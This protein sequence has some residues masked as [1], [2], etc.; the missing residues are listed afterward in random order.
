SRALVSL[1][2]WDRSHFIGAPFI[3]AST[4]VHELG[5][6]FELYHGGAV[7]IW[8]TAGSAT[9]V[10]P[11]CKPNYL[12]AMSYLFQSRGLLDN[13]NQPHVDYS[14]AKTPDTD[15]SLKMPASLG[16]LPYRT[17]WYEP[18]VPGTTAFALG[19]PAAKK[20]CSGLPFPDGLHPS[21]GIDMAR[22]DAGDT[23]SPIDWNDLSTDIDLD[24]IISG[25]AN[26]TPLLHGFDDWGHL[27]LDQTGAG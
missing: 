13:F 21:N 3:Q 14:T 10:E 8:G 12:S 1:G 22:V 15:E 23:S 6:N 17:A 24:G 7:P 25:A 19:L 11:N 5:H 18:L 4:T 27:R 2:L 20:Y 26:L 16:A 9:Y